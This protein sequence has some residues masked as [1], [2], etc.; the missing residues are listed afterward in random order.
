MSSLQAQF[1]HPGDSIPETYLSAHGCEEF[2][3]VRPI[4]DS[5]FS[6]MQGRSYRSDCTVPR[7]TLRYLTCLHR[8]L[9]GTAWMGEMVL[10]VRIADVVCDILR[11]LYDARYPIERM[12]LIDLW[13]ADDERSMRANNS[14]SFCF[15]YVSHTRV[16]SKHGQGLAVDINPLYNP[17]HKHL[18]DSTEVIEPA[19]ATAYLDRTADFPYKVQRGD[20]CHRLFTQHGFSWGGNWRTRKDYQHFELR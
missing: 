19:N 1:F 18:P 5:I 14:S 16:I 9:E 11:Q 17:Y 7:Q 20:L 2:F 12:R 13:D 4:P 10:N 8:D 6:V 3:S 15:R